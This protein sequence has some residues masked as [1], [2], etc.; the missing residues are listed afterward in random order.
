MRQSTSIVPDALSRDVYL[1]LDGRFGLAWPAADVAD[2]DRPT[3]GQYSSPVRIVAFNTAEG[4][5]RDVT[6]DIADELRNRCAERGEG[7]SSLR[8]FSTSTGADR[9]AFFLVSRPLMSFAIG[10]F[11]PMAY[12]TVT[13]SGIIL[14]P[15]I[16]SRWPWV[17]SF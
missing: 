1:V 14:K 5:S 10:L 12:L 15:L 16:G 6:D 7:P 9:V 2:T 4:W 17:H 3:M 11:C 8:D 13:R